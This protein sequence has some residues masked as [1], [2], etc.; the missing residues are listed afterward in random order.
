METGMNISY[1]N[2]SLIKDGKRWFPIMGE[3]HYSRYPDSDWKRE[4]L[5][6]KAGGVDLVSSY[7]IWIHHEEI[8][9]EWDFSDWRNLRGFVGAV[10]DAG[11]AM[12]LRIGPWVH[13]EVRNG[14]FPDWLLQ[15]CPN[16][17]TNNEPYFKEVGLYFEKVF[18]QVQGLLNKDGGP[19]IGVQIENEF[20]HCGGL[21][22]KEGEKH[23]QYL[24]QMA[25]DAGFDVPLY[26]AT[27]WGGAIT[28]GMLPVMGGYCE[29]PWDHRTT[30]IEPSGNY[31]FSH[32]RNDHNIGS[33]FGLG[34]G[35]TFD[36]TKYP[37][38]TAELGGGMEVSYK[39][40]PVARAK[41]IGAMSL[42]KMGS[43]CNL[44]GYYMYHG[45]MN[46]DGKVT[47]LEEN[48]ATGSYNDMP[49]KNYDFR[50]PLG[51]Y[52]NEN[53][54]YREI[55]MLAQFAKD[56]G[57]NICTM[58]AHIPDENPLVPT[59][60]TALR[61][62]FRYDEK[63]P[64]AGAYVFV[65]NFQRR[66]DMAEHDGV[67]LKAPAPFDSVAIPALDIYNGDFFFLPLLMK[68]GA[69]RL[70]SSACTPLCVLHN[71]GK[72]SYVFYT[73]S[74]L[75]KLS[76]DDRLYKTSRITTIQGADKRLYTFEGNDE[77]VEII[78]LSRKDAL[79][80]VKL[81]IA[82]ND[83]LT[84]SDALLYQEEDCVFAEG[85]GQ[86]AIQ[87]YPPLPATPNGYETAQTE[88]TG[89][90]VYKPQACTDEAEQA[91][92][93][94]NLTETTGKTVAYMLTVSQQNAEQGTETFIHIAYTGNAA[95]LY[96]SDGKLL[97]DD[98]YT[99]TGHE[100]NIGINRFMKGKDATF[101]FEIDV[102]DS[103]SDI[104]IEN[105]PDFCNG[106]TKASLDSIRTFSKR[107]SQLL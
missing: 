15:K 85:S 67:E 51:T 9:G 84:I 87:C 64:E 82:G 99:G 3:I 29:A 83:F 13:A 38:L 16:A 61:S 59:N 24:L 1:D 23:M 78:T 4:L 74:H 53:G 100:W 30:E 7:V 97:D 58:K 63:S 19:I 49:V 75:A 35:T 98:I 17:R 56:F 11:L 92:L 10:K 107:T 34:H 44:L 105:W 8:E 102:L 65:N 57:Q 69:A 103:T 40:R 62:S 80:A 73:A 45:G 25:K 81:S 52:G 93:A 76:K 70:L 47:T 14:G 54:S 95:R 60:F 41:D 32:E 68:T 22:G 91:T 90:T 5:K 43:G 77:T 33:D 104:F 37:Y 89:F 21:L 36:M 39:R 55:R 50:A 2:T 96:G 20:G 26:T 27:G 31:V 66:R 106:S 46:P 72:T 6:M 12:I 79:N 42:V 94:Y 71:A 101:R 18:E 88:Q 86:E 28:A 48:T